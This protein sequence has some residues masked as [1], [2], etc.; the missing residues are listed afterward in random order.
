MLNVCIN[1]W[2]NEAIGNKWIKW[3]KKS[4]DV[5][6]KSLENGVGDGEHKVAKELNTTVNGQ[7]FSYDMNIIIN[8]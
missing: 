6:F 3:T 2:E 8:R 5:P 4:E 7:N 1:I